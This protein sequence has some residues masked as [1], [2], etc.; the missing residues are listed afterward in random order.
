MRGFLISVFS[1][2]KN[3]YLVIPLLLNVKSYKIAYKAF[4]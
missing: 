4:V 1:I 2:R 3:E